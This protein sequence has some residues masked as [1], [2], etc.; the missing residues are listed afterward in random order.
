MAAWITKLT[1]QFS[2]SLID[3]LSSP[4]PSSSSSSSSS[5]NN[6]TDDIIRR[7]LAAESAHIRKQEADILAAISAALEKENIT[8]EKQNPG[9]SSNVLGRDIEQVREKVE[10]MK[11]ERNEK[12]GEGVRKAKEQVVRCYKEKS[13]RPLDCWKEVENFKGEVAKLEKVSRVVRRVDV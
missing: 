7:R 2:P 5:S 10:R 8:K 9:I 13:D 4:A 6:S 1:S 3:R 12:E 11:K